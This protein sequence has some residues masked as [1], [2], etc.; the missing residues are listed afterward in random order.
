MIRYM[1]SRASVS[2]ALEDL[3]VPLSIFGTIFLLGMIGLSILFSPGRFPVRLG[4]RTVRFRDLRAEEQ[5]LVGRQQELLKERARVLSLTPAPTLARLASL[6]AARMP[7][8]PGLVALET[9]RRDVVTAGRENIVLH[10]I[11]YDA[12]AG[13]LR[14]EGDAREEGEGSIRMLAL[15]VDKLRAAPLFASVSEPEYREVRDGSGMV[16]SPFLLT[17]RL[18]DGA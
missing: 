15:F 8:L 2:Q 17:I 11:S 3:A 16:S 7:A 6:R 9:A 12:S 13:I 14:V 4:E 5:L 1:F 10:A 18:S